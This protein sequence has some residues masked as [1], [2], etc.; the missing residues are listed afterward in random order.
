MTKMTRK[1]YKRK[2]I[3][4]GVCLFASVSLIATGFAAWVISANANKAKAGNV[5]VGQVSPTN[6]TIS[7]IALSTPQSFSF[8]PEQA[9]TTGRVRNDGTNFENL[10]I[11]LTCTVSP[12]A[13]VKDV[14]IAMSVPSG[15]TASAAAGKDYI[16][17]PDCVTAPVTLTSGSGL[18]EN[19][20]G[21]DVSYEIAFSWGTAFGGVNPGEYY[22]NNTDGKAKDITTV[23]NELTDFH[24]LM[25][26]LST[27]FNITVTAEIN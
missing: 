16:V 24:D 10:K 26:N 1:T 2:R 7:D 25:G 6:I 18:T 20:T 14:T 12:K 19:G 17:L 9:D 5:T 23:T 21:Y 3:I 27:G 22:D 4:L 15:V 11:T 13:Y 8:E